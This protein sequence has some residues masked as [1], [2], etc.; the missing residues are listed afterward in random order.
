[1]MLGNSPTTSTSTF[2]HKVIINVKSFL[3]NESFTNTIPCQLLL[4][5]KNKKQLL[6]FLHYLRP[7]L[8]NH[9]HS[10]CNI[11]F[12]YDILIFQEHGNGRL[13]HAILQSEIRHSNIIF[14]FSDN[15]FFQF[16]SCP[17][18]FPLVLLFITV[19]LVT[20]V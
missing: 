9:C 6:H 14:I 13:C 2:L 18:R 3:A 16:N 4:L 8:A 7:L 10:L 19:F 1:M 5:Y 20:H 15:F 12:L 11:S 17:H